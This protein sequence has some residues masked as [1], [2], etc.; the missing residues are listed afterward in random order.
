MKLACIS[1]H[2]D[3]RN[4]QWR[5]V[6]CHTAKLE[7]SS[8]SWC[9]NSL[10]HQKKTSKTEINVIDIIIRTLQMNKRK[11]TLDTNWQRWE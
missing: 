5:H 10:V 8:D 1:H 6:Q 4:R 11:V 2:T 3:K 9:S 7:P